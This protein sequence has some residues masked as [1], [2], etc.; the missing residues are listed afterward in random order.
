MCLRDWLTIS[1]NV[2]ERLIDYITECVWETDWL[3]YRMC[4]RDWLT[5]LQN[6][7][8]R[9][10]DYMPLPPVE[11][12][13]SLTEPPAIEFTKVLDTKPFSLT[14]SESINGFDDNWLWR[15]LHPPVLNIDQLV[16]TGFI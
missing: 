6:V 12:D 10:I 3:Y 11:E 4:L 8:E 15:C 14:G 1:Q 16:T 9:L 13:G 2:F 5:K 7:F